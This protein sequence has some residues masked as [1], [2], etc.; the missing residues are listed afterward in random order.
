MKKQSDKL[1]NYL[2]KRN[3]NR[4]LNLIGAA[5]ALTFF[6]CQNDSENLNLEST[7]LNNLSSKSVKLGVASYSVSGAHS[8]YPASNAFDGSTSTRWTS[9]GIG[10][11]LD[12]DLGE[13]NTVDY[14]MLAHYKGSSRTYNFKIY[15]KSSSSSSFTQVGNKSNDSSDKLQTYDV[16]NS[17]ARYIRI[18]SNG[19]SS[20]NWSDISEVEIWGT[21]DTSSDPTPTPTPTPTPPGSTPYSIL[22]SVIS[23]FK[24]TYPVDE[25]GNDSS[26]A[27]DCDDRNTDAHEQTDL[28]SAISSAYSDYF[29]VSGDEVVFKAHVGGATT[30]GS[31]YPRSEFRQ[32]VGGD[33][34]YWSMED[35]Q[36]LEVRVRATHLPKIKPEVSMVQIHGHDDE[37]LR[38]E[39]RTD[40]QGLHVVQN[41][42]NTK[43]YVLD[44]E[45]GQ[46]LFITVTVNNGNITLYILNEDTNEDYN[47]TWESED[48]KGYFKVGCYTQSSNNLETC[49]S[50]EGWDN[51]DANEYGEVRIKDLKLTETY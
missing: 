48:P 42:N 26:N 23:D 18:E 12:I 34:N 6:S 22:G 21:G 29:Y 33:D 49:K 27:D 20:N 8:Q 35:Y 19:G 17:T 13:D 39:Y 31:N 2:K 4:S 16:T 43:T 44:Y 37:P 10:E 41:E 51:Q 5:L 1:S 40:S 30:S 50:G 38:I 3:V 7:S 14:L 15:T 24:I 47:A 25:D 9:N 46:Q 11:Y 28:T 45:L 36:Y 32:L